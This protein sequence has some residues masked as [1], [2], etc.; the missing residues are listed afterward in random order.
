MLEIW[1]KQVK[2]QYNI[3]AGDLTNVGELVLGMKNIDK[4]KKI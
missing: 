2:R 1:C 4:L 3:P